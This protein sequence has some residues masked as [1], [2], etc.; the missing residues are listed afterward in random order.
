MRVDTLLEVLDAAMLSYYVKS[1]WKQMGGMMLVGPPGDLKSTM[2]KAAAEPHPSTLVLSDLTLPSFK[3]MRDDVTSGRYKALSFTEFEKIY[4]RQSSTSQNL[5]GLIKALTEE[6][7]RHFGNEDQRMPSLES[8][9][10]VQAAVT[11]ALFRK[12]YQEWSENGFSRRFLWLIFRLDD[13]DKI[14]NAIHE[15]KL[16]EM[17]KIT[18]RRPGNGSIPYRMEERESLYLQ[19]LV[20][21][22]PGGSIASQYVLLKKIFCVLRWKHGQADGK[23]DRAMEIIKDFSKCLTSKGTELIL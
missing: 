18:T 13:P 9:C 21:E 12:K 15:W 4:A 11:M 14:T 17:G 7:F 23:K 2:I 19:T 20:R 3:S 1:D 16:I 10:H 22:Q 8:R 6:G 5:E